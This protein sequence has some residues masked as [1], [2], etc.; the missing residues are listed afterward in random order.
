MSLETKNTK[1]EK[2]GLK[3]DSHAFAVF[4]Q[5]LDS[6]VEKPIT[7]ILAVSMCVRKLSKLFYQFKNSGLFR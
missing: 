5:G 2:Q 4:G 3:V 6:G 1:N 7:L